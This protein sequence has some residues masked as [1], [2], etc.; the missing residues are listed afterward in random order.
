MR[1][2]CTAQRARAATHATPPTAHPCPARRLYGT[3]FGHAG[4]YG[5]CA[6]PA[7]LLHEAHSSFPSGHSSM[8]FCNLGFVG[9]LGARLAG[10]RGRLNVPL[11]VGLPLGLAALIATSRTVK[12]RCCFELG[13]SAL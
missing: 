1:P 5:L 9:L 12:A 7:Q 11:Y 10:G 3:R 8:A 6:A 2:L 13:G 4:D